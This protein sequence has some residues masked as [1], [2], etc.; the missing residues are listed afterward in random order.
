M[1][2]PL[3]LDVSARQFSAIW[4]LTKCDSRI[5]FAAPNT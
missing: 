1:N 2:R 3:F 5:A 4:V